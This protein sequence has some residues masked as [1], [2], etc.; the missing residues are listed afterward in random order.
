MRLYTT[1]TDTNVLMAKIRQ[2]IEGGIN[3]G[4][5]AVAKSVKKDISKVPGPV[6]YPIQWTSAKQRR[7]YFAMRRK[8][9]GQELS[10][11]NSF[12]RR[13]GKIRTGHNFAYRRRVDVTS[14]DFSR[15]WSVQSQGGRSASVWNMTSY[16]RYVSGDEQQRFH[17]YTGWP[18]TRVVAWEYEGTGRAASIM[19]QSITLGLR[20]EFR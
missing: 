13:I 14:H 6:K 18:Q 9:V 16:A 19:A 3:Q 4:V 7:Y 11:T 12:G 1:I 15:N 20:T 8:I 10:R 2:G 5:I 17:R